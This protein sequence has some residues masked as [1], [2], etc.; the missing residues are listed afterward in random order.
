MAK[1]KPKQSTKLGAKLRMTQ[2]QSMRTRSY[3][4]GVEKLN[5]YD[6]WALFVASATNDLPKAQS[7]LEKDRRL[8][9][10]Q[11]WYQFSYS[12]G[13]PSWARSNGQAVIGPRCR[14]GAITIHVQLLGQ[15][16]VCRTA[17]RP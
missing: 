15:I 2:P 11:H 14:P 3:I 4:Y 6:A 17:S 8:V 10:A 7:L 9:N 5:G 12:H 13:G 1:R 16:V